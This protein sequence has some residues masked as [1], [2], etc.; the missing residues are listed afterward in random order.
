MK[1]TVSLRQAYPSIAQIAHEM[2][3]CHPMCHDGQP[4]CFLHDLES[5]ER[6]SSLQPPTPIHR[7][8][9]MGSWGKEQWIQCDQC[10]W[11]NYG[12]CDHV[13][14]DGYV[15]TILCRWCFSVPQPPFWTTRWNSQHFVMNMK[16]V[17]S[18]LQKQGIVQELV[19]FL[20]D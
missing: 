7:L 1:G 16:L 10:G 6:S 17:P 3:A 14:I 18:S 13:D 12:G 11:G 20:A 15:L 2:Y 19:N 9:N 5:L 4:F 8:F